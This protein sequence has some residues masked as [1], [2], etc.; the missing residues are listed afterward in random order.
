VSSPLILDSV[1][2]LFGLLGLAVTICVLRRREAGGAMRGRWSLALG[3]VAM[4]YLFRGV[5]WLTGWPL[6]DALTLA[7]VLPVPLAA[8]LLV[9]GL[10]RRHAPPAVKWLVLGGSIAAALLSL[11]W[12]QP[13][14]LAIVLG[15]HVGFGLLLSGYVAVRGRDGLA[16]AERRT[17]GALT[18]CLLLLLP[19][20]LSDF[21]HWFAETPVR[22]SPLAMLVLVW[23]GLGSAGVPRRERVGRLL[24]ATAIA[25]M[26]GFGLTAA[27]GGLDP[28]AASAVAMSALMLMLITE[29]AIVSPAATSG[30]RGILAAAPA[31][32]RGAL[33]AALAADPVIGS[34][35]VL[36]PSEIC[37]YDPEGL[38]A[39]FGERGLLRAGDAPWGR[40]DA[41]R[42]AQSAAAL[43]EAHAATHLLA[44]DREARTLLALNVPSISAGEAFETDL[45]IA[46]QMIRRATPRESCR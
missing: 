11:V 34:A 26:A 23:A 41:D 22:F 36:T 44:V 27:A 15:S 14:P 2:N 25:A 42:Q 43:F 35:V 3:L 30:L 21:R 33:L 45:A 28:I 38:I 29:E 12:P 40:A 8:L 19:A 10:V 31:G 7:A 39:L 24:I 46:A 32:D 13:T 5:Y 18:L 20:V 16:P 6:F 37:D 9:E 17:L 1:V 4:L